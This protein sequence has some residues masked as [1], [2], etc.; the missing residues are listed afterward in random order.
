MK[1]LSNNNYHIIRLDYHTHNGFY[2]GSGEIWFI[3]EGIEVAKSRNIK[4][5]GISPKL[6]S[7][8]Q[9]FIK[10]L[11]LEKKNLID[12]NTK[13]CE[14]NC[15]DV[16]DISIFT[17]IELDISDPNGKI[18]LM[19][20][21]HR[22][23][24]FVMAAPHQMPDRSLAWEDLD[25]EDIDEYFGLLKD[26]LINTFSKNKGIINIWAHP[27][28]QEIQI[29]A[30]IYRPYILDILK[31]VIEVCKNNNIAI[32][33]NENYFR[34]QTP[35]L[36]SKKRWKEFADQN[37][38]FARKIRILEEI[39]SYALKNSIKFTFGSDTHH[40]KQVGA[41]N[42]CVE[43]AKKIGIKNENLLILK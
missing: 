31:E 17:G 34:K 18:L 1:N 13:N 14:N 19:K 43:F 2:R 28:L 22:F 15:D 41:I 12:K 32:E 6:E 39:F 9:D 21:N 25:K 27:F 40:L 37:T 3:K 33:I 8:K 20:E 23:L 5:L 4:L 7:K 42:N 29:A 10:K 36:D 26:I 35:S 11:Y 16:Q 38:Y 24:D 30:D